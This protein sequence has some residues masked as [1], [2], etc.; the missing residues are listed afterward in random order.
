MLFEAVQ[1]QF[2]KNEKSLTR[3]YEFTPKL[4]DNSKD[5]ALK[6]REKIEHSSQSK[7]STIEWLMQPS[8]D[9]KWSEAAKKLVE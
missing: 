3:E 8:K 7:L 2:R 1:I 9:P 5:L 6:F 4:S